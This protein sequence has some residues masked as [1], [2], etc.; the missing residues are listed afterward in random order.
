MSQAAAIIDLD[1]YRR[2]K[3]VVRDHGGATVHPAMAVVPVVWVWWV[4]WPWR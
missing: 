1:E 4:L 2:R 3:A